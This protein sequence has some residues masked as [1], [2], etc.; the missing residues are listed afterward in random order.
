MDL[1]KGWYYPPGNYPSPE[2]TKFAPGNRPPEQERIVFQPS[3]FRGELLVSG[4]VTYP[5]PFLFLWWHML[6]SWRVNQILCYRKFVKSPLIRISMLFMFLGPPR[7]LHLHSWPTWYL[8]LDSQWP[9]AFYVN[10]STKHHHLHNSAK[11]CGLEV[12]CLLQQR[13]TRCQ[14]STCCDLKCSKSYGYSSKNC[15]ISRGHYE[16]VRHSRYQFLPKARHKNRYLC[17]YTSWQVYT[18]LSIYLLIYLFIIDLSINH[19]CMYHV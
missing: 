9:E 11:D 14:K 2:T 7:R 5:L 19:Q 12:S 17:Q 15:R 16:K 1:W 4:R 13:V 6:V 18:Y 3:I 10:K 8:A